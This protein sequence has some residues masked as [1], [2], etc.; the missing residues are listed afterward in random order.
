MGKNS[1]EG[2]EVFMAKNKA[3]KKRKG[4]KLFNFEKFWCWWNLAEAA[5]ILGAGICAIVCGAL[6]DKDNAGSVVVLNHVLP[7]VVGGFVSMDA[8]L[9]IVLGLNARG[10]ETDESVMLIGGFELTAGILVMIFHDQFTRLIINAIGT[11][12]IVIGTL[13]VLFS[14]M[15]IIKKS[16]KLFVPILE[17]VF[18]SILVGVGI[19]IFIL[20]YMTS[21]TDQ[22]VLLISG[23]IFTIIGLGQGIVTAAKLHKL[24]RGE[25]LVLAGEEPQAPAKQETTEKIE[26]AKAIDVEE[27]TPK[28]IE[29]AKEIPALENKDGEAK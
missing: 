19:A 22:V 26:K 23:I 27:V 10:K 8:I 29:E 5:L 24:N 2:K 1:Q 11:L 18:A 9:R 28:A 20:Y 12:I 16:K 14:A 4:P 21:S 15:A 17:I 3:P 7:Y 13:L 6:Y 25:K